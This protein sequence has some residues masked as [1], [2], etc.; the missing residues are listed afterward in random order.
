MELEC[1]DYKIPNTIIRIKMR[2]EL[3]KAT[4]MVR[5]LA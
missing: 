4:E 5:T 1:P 3:K 2:A